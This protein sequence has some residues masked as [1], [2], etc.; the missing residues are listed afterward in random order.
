VQHDLA[1]GFAPLT[2]RLGALVACVANP[3][4]VWVP[5]PVVLLE[6]WIPD[7]DQSRS[8]VLLA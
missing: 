3:L 2:V 8:L 5:A 6:L 4:N 7:P 1:S